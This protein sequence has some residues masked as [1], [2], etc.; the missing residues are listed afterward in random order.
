MV[1]ICMK[2]LFSSVVLFITAST[3]YSQEENQ[4]Q[5]LPQVIVK[6]TP[7]SLLNPLYPAAHFSAEYKASERSGYQLDLGYLLP[8]HLLGKEENQFG[9]FD[10]ENNGLFI[11]MEYRQYLKRYPNIYFGTQLQ[12]IFNNY[13]RTD[14]FDATPNNTGFNQF[15][16]TCLED[17]YTIKKNAIGLNLKMGMQLYASDRL[18]IDCYAGLG[19]N[20]LNNKHSKNTELHRNPTMADSP[21]GYYLSHYPGKYIFSLPTVAT[22]IRIGYSF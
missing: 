17:T 15:C 5:K 12:Y 9:S 11:K 7:T 21:L 13:K 19:V 14:T 8:H 22:G 20:Y 18:M 16:S 4:L 3:A 6:F 10:S 1:L 2:M